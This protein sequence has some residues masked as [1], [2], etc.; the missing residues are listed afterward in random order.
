MIGQV[1]RPTGKL[2]A[3]RDGTLRE[4]IETRRKNAQ[5]A[6]RIIQN[7]VIGVVAE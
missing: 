2:L 3:K 5:Y 1:H 4:R 7:E 6:S